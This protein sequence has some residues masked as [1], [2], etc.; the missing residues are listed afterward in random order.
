MRSSKPLA[1]LTTLLALGCTESGRLRVDGHLAASSEAFVSAQSAT[2]S[3]DDTL[4]IE[5]ARVRVSEIEFEGGKEDER[6]AELGGTTID[7]ALDGGLTT[8]AADSVEAGSY[9]T[10]GLELRNSR[11]IIVQGTYDGDAFTFE[12]G[13][14]PELEFPLDPPVDVPPN[15]E[16]SVEVTFDVAA[17]FSDEDAAALDPSDAD[18][19]AVIEQRILSSMEAYAEIEREDDDDD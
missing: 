16:A 2:L 1:L 10:L 6:E 19:Q 4:V 11:S 5:S 13:L 9:H 8:V 14:S 15:G 7:L 17:W 12:S 3:I 18:N